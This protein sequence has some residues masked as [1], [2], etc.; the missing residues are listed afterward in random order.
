MDEFVDSLVPIELPTPCLLVYYGLHEF[1]V[2]SLVIDP[3]MLLP[4]FVIPHV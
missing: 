2:P 1:L 4:Y 3:L